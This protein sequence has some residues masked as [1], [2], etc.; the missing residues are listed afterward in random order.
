M[1]SLIFQT[2]APASFRNLVR[3]LQNQG[4]LYFLTDLLVP[5]FLI[6][7]IMFGILNYV[8]VFKAKKSN[9]GDEDEPDRKIN[10]TISGLIALLV[11]IPHI[12]GAYAPTK[13][14][15]NIIKNI[16]PGGVLI[17]LA[18]L[19]I[20]AIIILSGGNHSSLMTMMVA[21][22]G[23]F[24]LFYIIAASVFPGMSWGPFKD[25]A[26]QVLLI[27]LLVAGLWIYFLLK[28]PKK[29]ETNLWGWPLIPP[30]S[31]TP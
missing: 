14:P 16:L 26:T 6:F 12:I 23:I 19:F 31:K 13:D 2:T 27:S 29:E 30:T 21:V 28:P 22:A 24:F 18:I 20:L 5:F 9:A 10:A 25:P 15:I 8:K 11:V 1:F 7:S 4:V 17:L 3:N